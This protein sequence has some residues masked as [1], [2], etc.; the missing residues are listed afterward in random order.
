MN[1][2]PLLLVECTF[3]NSCGEVKLFMQ[4]L[5]P[6]AELKQIALHHV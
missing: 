1:S 3:Q 4:G 2:F 5:S 6:T